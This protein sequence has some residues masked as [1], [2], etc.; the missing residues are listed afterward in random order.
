[1]AS[2]PKTVLIVDDDITTAQTHK[3]FLE[4]NGYLV[5]VI[6]DGELAV[7]A[8]NRA[9]PDVI[10]LDIIMPK[11]DGFTVAKQLRFH[12]GTRHIPII[13][14]SAQT[15]MKDLFAIEGIDDYLVKPVDQ[16]E[17]LA[18]VRRRAG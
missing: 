9:Q 1:M 7:E 4:K 15:E 12:E 5:T 8:A 16:Q 14:C 13:I 2:G 17:L 3:D 11:I 10:L 18:L 6:D